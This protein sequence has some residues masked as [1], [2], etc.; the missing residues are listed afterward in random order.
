M[1]YDFMNY[2]ELRRKY[3]QRIALDGTLGWFEYAALQEALKA[4]GIREEEFNSSGYGLLA[5]T[6]YN[7]KSHAGGSRDAN[8]QAAQSAV[9][10][11]NALRGYVQDIGNVM[12]AGK[13]GREDGA[14]VRYAES[15]VYLVRNQMIDLRGKLNSIGGRFG[16]PGIGGQSTEE[17]WKGLQKALDRVQERA[18]SENRL[19]DEVAQY[20]SMIQGVGGAVGMGPTGKGVV[21]VG[22]YCE[23]LKHTITVLRES[24]RDATRGQHDL[25]A[26]MNNLGSV[27]ALSPYTLEVW[28]PSGLKTWGDEA[29][30]RLRELSESEAKHYREATTLRAI[31][32]RMTATIQGLCEYL[33]VS[34][35]EVYTTPQAWL[36]AVDNALR[37]RWKGEATS[38]TDKREK[39]LRS[40]VEDLKR[41]TQEVSMALEVTAPAGFTSLGGWVDSVRLELASRKKAVES[42]RNYIREVEEK[43]EARNREV[44]DLKGKLEAVET[45]LGIV[46]RDRDTYAKRGDRAANDR[47]Q[48]WKILV[49]ISQSIGM[50]QGDVV[51]DPTKIL[52]AVQLLW[53]DRYQW[54]AKARELETAAVNTAPPPPPDHSSPKWPDDVKTIVVDSISE[55]WKILGIHQTAFMDV[56]R[57]I[58]RPTDQDPKVIVEAVRDLHGSREAWKQCAE[59]GQRNADFWKGLLMEVGR[60]MGPEVRISDDGT[61]QEDPLAMKV[62]PAVEKLIALRGRLD[63]KLQRARVYIKVLKGQLIAHGVTPAESKDHTQDQTQDQTPP[64]ATKPTTAESIILKAFEYPK[65]EE[66]MDR[67][68]ELV[69]ALLARVEK[70]ELIDSMRGIPA[71]EPT[72]VTTAGAVPEPI[73]H[74]VTCEKKPHDPKQGYFHTESYD[75]QCMDRHGRTYCGRCHQFLEMEVYPNA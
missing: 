34:G 61:E 43:L 26:W 63:N 53:N 1:D 49:D 13:M 7:L 24:E 39:E 5:S 2:D 10:E 4:A 50:D 18:D 55:Y 35:P 56:C 51:G 45:E 21:G 57:A 64:P 3:S 30:K 58:G 12:G 32:D 68:L 67:A 42:R 72:T 33:Q 25:R 44:K 17:W 27:V 8:L 9:A 15:M 28:G 41:A 74:G 38:L 11:V 71:T 36:E 75:G 54:K 37:L 20:Q 59:Q 60:L 47:N 46:K 48:Y 19:R 23:S 73:V 22:Q 6:I 14:A 52:T 40:Q 29:L 65:G 16:Y 70:L 31:K 66:K 62:R 69:E